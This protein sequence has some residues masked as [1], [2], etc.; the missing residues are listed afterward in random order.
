MTGAGAP[1]RA[2][3]KG[4]VLVNG[5]FLES[6]CERRHPRET[7]VGLARRLPGG[8]W[9]CHHHNGTRRREPHRAPAGECRVRPS[10]DHRER[11]SRLQ[12]AQR[13]LNLGHLLRRLRKRV[14]AQRP[15]WYWRPGRGHS[16]SLSCR[17]GSCR[18]PRPKYG[19]IQ[20]RVPGRYLRRHDLHLLGRRRSRACA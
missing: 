9:L 15:G 16:P 7:H 20:Q 14:H 6:P 10:L 4:V 12:A 3:C 11:R 2:R 19:I 5:V 1:R 17:N 13:R 18:L 8:F